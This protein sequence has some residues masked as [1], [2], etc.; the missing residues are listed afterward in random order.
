[1]SEMTTRYRADIETLC[2]IYQ[3]EV[4]CGFGSVLTDNFKDQSVV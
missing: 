3:V 2:R 1:M 4:P